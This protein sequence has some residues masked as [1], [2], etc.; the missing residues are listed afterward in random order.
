MDNS[1]VIKLDRVCEILT[2]YYKP[3]TPVQW[4]EQGGYV[5][6]S[7]DFQECHLT[8]YYGEMWCEVNDTYTIVF[9]TIATVDKMRGE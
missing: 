4:Y 1:T 6:I 7:V 3:I 2:D 8:A 5:N 9:D